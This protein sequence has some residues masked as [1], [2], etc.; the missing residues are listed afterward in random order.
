MIKHILVALD[1]SKLSLK[2]LDEA[3]ELAKQLDA[4]IVLT[5]IM[6]QQDTHEYELIEQHAQ[7]IVDDAKKIVSNANLECESM[8]LYGSPMFDIEKIVRKSEADLVV[9]GT[10]GIKGRDSRAIGSLASA[11]IKNIKKPVMLVK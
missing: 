11:T 9:M 4:K 3:I 6:D 5:H 1:G 10:H 7:N 8:I 2:A